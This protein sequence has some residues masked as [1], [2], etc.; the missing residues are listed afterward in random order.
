[1]SYLVIN[2]LFRSMVGTRISD[3]YVD[4]TAVVVLDRDY[5][6]TLCRFRL[7]F[8]RMESRKLGLIVTPPI[9]IE[10]I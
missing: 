8:V 9:H 4:E 2:Y 6:Q 3:F 1:M 10:K 5:A 7:C